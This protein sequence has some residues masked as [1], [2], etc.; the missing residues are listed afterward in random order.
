MKFFKLFFIII[1]ACNSLV[2]VAQR[3]DISQA[4]QLIKRGNN[5]EQAEE[6][7]RKLLKDSTNRKNEKIW[8]TLFDAIRKQYE[9]GNEQLYLKQPYDTAKLFILTKKMFDVMTAF[10]SIDAQPDK[11]GQ[12]KFKYRD[13]HAQYLKQFRPNLF[14]G[15]SYFNHKQK[16]RDAYD[17]YNTYIDC[18]YQPLFQKYHFDKSDKLL[19]EASYWAAYCA[20]K[21]H[22]H[23]ATLK[24]APLAL[25]DSIHHVYMLQYLAETYKE[26]KDTALY[27]TVLKDGF[28]SYPKFAFFFPRLVDYYVQ[29]KDFSTALDVINKGLEKDSTNHLYLFAKST[30]LLNTGNYDECI[31][32]CDKLI[33]EDEHTV[34]PYLNAGLA[35]FNKAVVLDKETILS[36]KQRQQILDYYHKAMPYLERYREL[37]PNMQEKWSLPLYTI[38]LNLNMGTKFDEIDKLINGSKK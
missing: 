27:L 12:I 28:K 11:K 2:V 17:L 3:K 26:K 6:S 21:L 14:N 4:K 8:L 24:H 19:P 34:E 30:V 37:E 13:A 33:S 25:K 29:N 15:G 16:F 23:Q 5:L 35:Y 31:S 9:Q 22:D 7:M 1:I 32:I 18:A 36:R 38:Y 20:F 10:D